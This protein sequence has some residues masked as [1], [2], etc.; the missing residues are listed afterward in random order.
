MNTLS[1]ITP[2]ASLSVSCDTQCDTA[3]W[4]S[5]VRAERQGTFFQLSGW[6]KVAKTAYGYDAFYI[7]ARRNGAL[8][9]VLP[10]TFAKTSLLGASLISTAFSVG[11]GPLARDGEALQALLHAAQQ[12]GE[13]NNVRYIECRS[14]F[15]AD[16]WLKKRG[17]HAGFEIALVEDEAEALSAVPR[18]RRAEIRKAIAA[19]NEGLLSIRHNGE[20]DLFYKLYATSLHRLGTPVFPRR[21]LSTL[22][23]AF[24]TETEI[25]VVE[26]RGEPVA[27]LVSFYFKD[28]VLPYYIGAS[29][30]A[31]S[32]RAF[33]CVYWAVMRR[34]A[35]KGCAVFDF[36]RSKV[37]TGAYAYKRLWGAEPRPV[38]YRINLI[39]DEALPDINA[40]NPKF[41]AFSKLWPHLPGFAANRLGPLLAPNFP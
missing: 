12:L 2:S 30:K 1:P 31:R 20:P 38:T 4:D 33:D 10:L 35:E 11:G 16:S 41:A 8:A 5:Y 28:K 26:Y 7:T 21:F 22:M 36:G 17:L 6:A 27:A 25:S 18:K 15:D 3:E 23:D 24:P 9:G 34:A 14:D 13:D 40:N 29:E 19:A 39:G 37:D 32:T